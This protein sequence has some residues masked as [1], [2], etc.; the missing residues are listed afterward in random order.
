MSGA[1]LQVEDLHV[2]YRSGGSLSG[3]KRQKPAVRGVSFAV[4]QGK[5]FGLVGESGSG[6]SSVGK[7]ILRLVE[8]TSGSVVFDGTDVLAMGRRT[9]LTYRSDV[10]VIFQDPWSSLNARATIGR[11]LTEPLR[12]HRRVPKGQERA[13]VEQ[14][15]EQVGMSPAHAR[16]LPAELSG[17]QRQR[18]AIARALAVE[19]RLIVCDEPVSALDVSTQGQVIN[20]LQDLQAELGLTYVFIAHDL[21]VVRHLSHNIAVMA[22]GEIVESGEADEVY[23]RPKHAYTRAL[24]E[25][26][27]TPDPALQ[28]EL[29][30]R[31]RDQVS[32]LE[33]GTRAE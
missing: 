23:L 24:L 2:S 8:P 25:A 7:A 11:I 29:R 12:R 32:A 30:R 31:R 22:A 18:V 21:S 16:R 1:I 15:L 10:Q 28:R 20:L 6:K 13:R 14:L 4:E 27:P 17:G 9:P 5:T 33:L 3:R 19:P 26:E